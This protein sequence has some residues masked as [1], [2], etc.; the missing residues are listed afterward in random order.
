MKLPDAQITIHRAWYYFAIGLMSIFAAEMFWLVLAAY[1]GH[2][3]QPAWLLWLP[4]V[5]LLNCW[6][7]TRMERWIL[8]FKRQRRLLQELVVAQSIPMPREPRHKNI[9]YKQVYK[10][11]GKYAH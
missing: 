1:A 7:I 9:T 11:R 8:F 2:L 3:E 5:F 6:F 4:V 10:Q